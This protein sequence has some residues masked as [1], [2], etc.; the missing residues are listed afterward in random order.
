MR[1]PLFAA[2]AFLSLV[3][4]NALYAQEQGTPRQ[5]PFKAH[6]VAGN[7]YMLDGAG[8]GNVAVLVGS[9]GLVLV[10]AHMEPQHQ[11]L[12]AALKQLSDK[13]VHKRRQC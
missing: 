1:T 4:C 13:P 10:D 6:R 12:L 11:L 8:G 5:E 9:D 3:A 2:T 7:V